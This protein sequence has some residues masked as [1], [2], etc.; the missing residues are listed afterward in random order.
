[1]Y[2]IYIIYVLFN[3]L[4][5]ANSVIRVKKDQIIITPLHN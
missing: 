2:N 4:Y 1:M 5:Y 3:F